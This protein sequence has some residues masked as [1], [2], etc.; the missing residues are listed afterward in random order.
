MSNKNPNLKTFDNFTVSTEFN[1][2]SVDVQEKKVI[3]VDEEIMMQKNQ[4]K[5]KEGLS[6]FQ[7]IFLIICLSILVGFLMVFVA[8]AL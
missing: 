8:V 7:Q 6:G 3:Y 5:E 1:E 2:S 4:N